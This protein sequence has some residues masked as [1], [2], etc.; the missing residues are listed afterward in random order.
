MLLIAEGGLL[1]ISWPTVIWGW[2]IFFATFW[3]LS[4]VAWPLLA[5]KMEER[6]IRIKEGL[7]KAEEAEKRATELMQRQEE[8][9]QEAREE[10]QKLL[11][12][13]RTAAENIKNETVA[14]AQ[15]EIAAERERAKKEIDLERAKAMHELRRTA[16][17]PTLEAAGRVIRRELKDDDH[18]R[19]A[20][21]VIAEVESLK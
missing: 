17:D 12:D 19:L 9:L 15:D 11:G 14:R 1:D 21:D 16:V 6:E 7:A 4:K 5:A 13:S 2:V 10:A 18:Q 20:A 3:A 8:I